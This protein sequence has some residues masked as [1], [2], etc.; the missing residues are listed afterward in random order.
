MHRDCGKTCPRTLLGEDEG[1]DSH[2][3]CLSPVFFRR[4]LRDADDPE[5]S[6]VLVLDCPLRRLGLWML[7]EEVIWAIDRLARVA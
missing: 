4:R 6:A 1:Q 2:T 7:A 5:L 3:L